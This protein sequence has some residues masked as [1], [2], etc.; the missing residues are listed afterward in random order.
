[1]QFSDT[2]NKTGAIQT[3]EHLCRLGDAGI[4]GN[5][6]L[7]AQFTGLINRAYLEV[8]TAILSVD[9]NCKFDDFNYTD[10]PEASITLVDA[11]QDYTLP[12]AVTGQNIATLLRVNKVWVLDSNGDRH[13]LSPMGP[14][15]DFDR[16]ATG[17]PTRYR[18]NGK[19]ILLDVL[20]AK[21]SVKLSGGLIIAFQRVPD[22]FTSA[23]TTQQPGFME[24]YHDLLPLRASSWY[25]LPTNPELALQYERQFLSRIEQLKGSYATFDDNIP[26][27]LGAMMEDNR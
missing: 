20:P 13:Q 24:T 17:L 18:I 12:V 4:S 22:A 25:L 9:K 26:K 8:T 16:E 3:A 19:S 21:E 2:T 27:R 15:D 7:L 11:Q 6:V 5:A 1:M 10:F 23:D 14:D